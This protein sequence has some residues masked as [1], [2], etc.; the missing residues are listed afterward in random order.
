MSKVLSIGDSGPEVLKWK[1]YLASQGFQID[2]SSDRFDPSTLAATRRMQKRMG[3]KAD[4]K[5]GHRTLGAEN[6]A[7]RQV[8]PQARPDMPPAP[9]P[10]PG[11]MADTAMPDM[12]APVTDINAADEPFVSSGP[13]ADLNSMHSMNSERAAVQGWIKDLLRGDYVDVRDAEPAP[14][15]P[16]FTSESN[17]PTAQALMEAKGIQPNFDAAGG[18][19]GPSMDLSGYG[20][21][22]SPIGAPAPM[23]MDPRMR[24]QVIRLLLQGAG[25]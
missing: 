23:S 18:P 15:N 21:P 5:V 9:L 13:E 16:Q 4:G 10:R 14:I 20:Q 11:G 19:G 6:R 3:V 25:V 8:L 22:Q 24:D 2:T 1:Q 17:D 12:G 7:P